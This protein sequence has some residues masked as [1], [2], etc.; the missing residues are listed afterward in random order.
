M[1]LDEATILGLTKLLPFRERL[2]LRLHAWMSPKPAALRVIFVVFVVVLVAVFPAL[3]FAQF[4]LLLR[5]ASLASL[6]LC[7]WAASSVT[8]RVVAT[9]TIWVAGGLLYWLRQKQRLWYG[10]IEMVFATCLFWAAARTPPTGELGALATVFGAIYVFIRGLDNAAT[11]VKQRNEKEAAMHANF[12][13]AL[14]AAA[15]AAN[16]P[17]GEAP[18]TPRL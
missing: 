11:G 17:D 13:E 6:W 16:G 4:Y 3:A 15:A 14:L 10:W 18:D 5:P 7:R 8:H 2:R 1:A 12:T 9:A